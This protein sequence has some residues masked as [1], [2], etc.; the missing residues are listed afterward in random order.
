MASP[1]SPQPSVDAK[2]LSSSVGKSGSIASGKDVESPPEIDRI[3]ER[4]ALWKI[5]L[6]IIPLVGMYYLLSFIVSEPHPNIGNARIAGLQKGLHMTNQD[7]STALTVTYVPYIAMELPMNLLM[8]R[9]GAN[10]T[11]PLMVTLWG[12]VCACQGAV[13][14]YGGL[15]ACRFFLGALEGGLFPGITLY[16][17]QFYKRHQMQLRFAMM[18][19]STSLAGAFSGL[20]AAAIQNMD[21]LRGLSGWAWIFIL[22]G[23]FT[24]VFGLATWVLIPA[25]PRDLKILTPS[26]RDA[27]TAAL[28]EDWSG[29]ADADGQEEDAFSWN[30]VASVF[31]NA[32][33][34][35]ISLVMLLFNGVTLFG[36]ANFTPT[37][38]GAL[39]YS[40][41]HTQLLTVPPYACSFVVS[42][43][44]SYAS[45][46]MKQRGAM[47]TI[48]SLV[49]AA[50]YAIFLGTSNMHANYGALFLQIIGVY[51]IAPCLSTWNANNVQPHVRRATGIAL[52][53]VSTNIGGIISTWI[54]T[55]PP[56]FHKASSINLAFS[57][58][59]ATVSLF[60]ILFLRSVNA[61][62]RE[63]VQRLEKEQPGG[64]WDSRAE[65][66]RLGDRH[67][68][69]EYTT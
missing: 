15:L 8:K 5:D 69:F 42:I 21:G 54:F 50:G 52:A 23:T 44:C 47:A 63:I 53:F 37:I 34:V 48:M 30:E 51:S 57:L 19:S 62:K 31:T 25:G 56:R 67:P 65:R 6:L 40:A 33:H 45:D 36:L 35:L 18:F 59:M 43:L 64:Q 2:E 60:L 20:L 68:R 11:L 61:R 1:P 16:L 46:R 38:V 29:D 7:F 39:G 32:P 14:S 17:S 49:A 22:E 4:K 12:M 26:E 9:L 66:R 10:V 58:G 24:T 55:D 28:A 41:T 3:E 27:Y 13:K